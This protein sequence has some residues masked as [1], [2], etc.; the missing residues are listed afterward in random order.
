MN[1]AIAKML[2][3]LGPEKKIRAIWVVTV[4]QDGS[5]SVVKQQ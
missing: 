3:M 2:G 4:F 5:T 1:D